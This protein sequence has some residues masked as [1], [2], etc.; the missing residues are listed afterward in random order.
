MNR[1]WKKITKKI[2][3][4]DSSEVLLSNPD[5]DFDSLPEGARVYRFPTPVIGIDAPLKELRS[6]LWSQ[7]K[8]R[9][10]VRD[11]ALVW[12]DDTH[13]GLGVVTTDA[14]LERLSNG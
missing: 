3:S 10:V 6:F 7:R 11:R 14:V 9:S 5:F 4:K 2:H 12:R 8:N 1:D 13:Y